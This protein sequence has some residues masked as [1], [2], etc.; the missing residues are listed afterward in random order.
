MMGFAMLWSLF[1][2]LSLC[3][4]IWLIVKALAALD[5]PGPE[6][7]SGRMGI[8]S[9]ARGFV[10]FAVVLANVFAIWDADRSEFKQWC[11]SNAGAEIYKTQ[12]V[13][14]FY[15]NDHTAASFGLSHLHDKEGFA[16]MEARSQYNPKATIRY[17]YGEH[18]LKSREP[19][20]RISKHEVL[21]ERSKPLQGVSVTTQQVWA[22]EPRELMGKASLAQFDGGRVKWFLGV[23]GS[24][25][26]PSGWSDP[27]SFTSYTGLVKNV[28]GSGSVMERKK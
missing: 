22:M 26:C 23:W 5:W 18:G 25:S 19:V 13:D 27:D 10:A 21:I 15:F 14:G 17:E 11:G 9:K 24:S 3:L 20:Q 7:G 6:Y 1:A 4:A 8:Q 28:L 2:P 16:W 12:R